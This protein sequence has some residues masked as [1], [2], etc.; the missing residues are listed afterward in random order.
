[1]KQLIFILIIPLHFEKNIYLCIMLSLHR[2]D[3]VGGKLYLS[4]KGVNIVLSLTLENLAIFVLRDD[5]TDT[6]RN[7]LYINI[8]TIG[9]LYIND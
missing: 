2:R 1:M 5:T 9:M 6:P 4:L 7:C 8:S 3:E